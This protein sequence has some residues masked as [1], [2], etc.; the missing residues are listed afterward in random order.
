MAVGGPVPPDAAGDGWATPERGGRPSAIRP[1]LLTAGRVSG[2]GKAPP[3]PIETQV[4]STSDGLSVLRSLTF[5]HHDIVAACRRPQ[6]VAELAARL[7]LHL[8]VVRVLAEDLCNAG[9]LAVYVPNARTA[10]DLSVLLRAIDG[11]R[12]VPDSRASL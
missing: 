2:G 6:S 11:L 8:N 5:E 12:A 9:H 7:R 3:I 4:V 1:F 10:Q